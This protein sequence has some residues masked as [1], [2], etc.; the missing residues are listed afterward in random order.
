MQWNDFYHENDDNENTR[1]AIV[2]VPVDALMESEGVLSADVLSK[3]GAVLLPAGVDLSLFSKVMP[4]FIKKMK[5]NDIE[6]VCINP[7]T[8]LRDD[9]IEEIISKVYS[10]EGSIITKERAQSV[11]NN[12]DHAFKEIMNNSQMGPDIV[13]NLTNVG[14]SLAEDILRNPSVTFS[15]SKVRDVDEYTFIHS[16]NVAVLTGFLANRMY[17]NNKA[18]VH[19][20]VVGALMHDLGKA[21]VPLEILNKPGPLTKDEFDQMQR[22]PGIGL[23]LAK[24]AGV[25]HSDILDVIVG[26]HEKWSG[27]GYPNHLSGSAIPTSAR[28]AAVAD[29]FDA[30]TARRVYKNPMPSRNAISIILKDSGVHF[31]KNISRELLTSIGLYPAGSM[32][33]LSNGKMGVVV[34]SNGADLVR[35]VVMLRQSKKAD[36]SEPPTFVD[37]KRDKSIHIT[38]YVG[39][40]DKRDMTG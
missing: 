28:I 30:L 17:P 27:H 19:R 4:S 26:H 39:Q 10:V 40:A 35:P 13:N 20:L 15:I 36:P 8:Q 2:R 25:T 33:M 12:V 6:T 38:T 32:V 21:Q 16:F 14:S 29:V 24:E 18:Y 9:D 3:S 22:H 1:P 23:E 11:V 34:T 5:E 31:D 37:L 7:P